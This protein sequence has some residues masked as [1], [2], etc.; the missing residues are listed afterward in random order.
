MESSP[1]LV[2]A[3]AK[4]PHN[5]SHWVRGLAAKLAAGFDFKLIHLTEKKSVL[6]M[7]L[8][9]SLHLQQP[10]Q[11]NG[12]TPKINNFIFFQNLELQTFKAKEEYNAVSPALAGRSI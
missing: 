6:T 8:A 2:Q 9:C 5:V 3:S 7:G 11:D 12:G 10:C 4:T 1:T